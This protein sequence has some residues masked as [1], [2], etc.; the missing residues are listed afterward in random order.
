MDMDMDMDMDMG[1]D[2][3]MDIEKIYVAKATLRPGRSRGCL[4][5]KVAPKVVRTTEHGVPTEP[6]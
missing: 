3:D 2:M 4:Y 1:M 6:N 5:N